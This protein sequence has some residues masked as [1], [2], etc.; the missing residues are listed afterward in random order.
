MDDYDKRPGELALAFDPAKTADDARLVF[1]GR[2]ETPWRAREECPKNIRQARERGRPATL[3]L[4]PP[5][6]PGLND[7]APGQPICVL[8]WMHEARR[9]L[10]VQ[11]PRHREQPAGVFSL[12]SPVRPNPIAL[13][14]V[15][16]LEVDAAEG[17]VVVDALDCLTGTPIL[18]IKPWIASVD[19][20]PDI[21]A[22]G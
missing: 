12:R 15:K 17:R 10:I 8:Y 16:V 6:R 14:I 2:A 11:A 18:D 13:A 19:L 9:D 7:L 3:A 4:D 21:A 22:A 20:P 5:W 1:I